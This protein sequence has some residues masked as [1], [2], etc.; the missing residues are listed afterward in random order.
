MDRFF[1]YF[2]KNGFL[3]NL[4]TVFLILIGTASLLTMKRDLVPQ[5]ER[6]RI[7]IAASLIG[8]SPEQIEELL[9][10]PIEE[11]VSSFSGIEDIE[12]TS[13]SSQSDVLINIRDDFQEVD[14]LYEKVSNAVEGIR[15]NLPE[16][17][18]NISI[19]N[20]K[21]TY[22]W[23]LS[24][25]VLGFRPEV[26]RHR[27]WL[28][29]TVD[30]LKK[31]PGI[32]RVE[33]NSPKPGFFFK[34]DRQK[35][36]RYDVTIEDVA[37]KIEDNFRILP[38]GIIDRSEK[39]VS[40]EIDSNLG[41]VEDIG[42]IIVK[43]NASG[44][45][46][47][48]KDIAL[49]EYRN[50]ES[51][52]RSY[53]NGKISQRVVVFKDF[54]TDAIEAKRAVSKLFEEVSRKAPDDLEIKITRD[55]PTYIEKQLKVLSTNGIFGSILVVLSLFLFLGFRS[56]VMTTL[57]LPLAYF[58]TFSVL[59]ALGIGI[60]LISIVGMILI[61]GII[62]DDAII[63]S[64]QYSQFLEKNHPPKE[65]ALM[66]IKKTIAPISGTVLTTIVAF[67]PILASQDGIGS[68]LRAIPWVVIAALAM[69]WIESFFILP[70]HLSHFVHRPSKSRV[71]ETFERIREVYRRILSHVLRLRYV[72]SL[73]MI[74][75]MGFS[76]WFAY[77]NIP[78]K[79]QLRAGVKRIRI[80]SVL[81]ES[82]HFD[83]TEKKLK[84][85]FDL[86]KELDPSR[87]SFINQVLGFTYING[88]RFEGHK[89]ARTFVLFDQED[90][91]IQKNKDFVE[92]FFKKRLP[93]IKNDDF[94]MLQ[95]D[96]RIDG[97]DE[98][99]E[100]VIN[101]KVEG[102]NDVGL[103]DLMSGVKKLYKD[104][105]GFDQVF[106][107]PQLSV[108][109]WDFR[110]NRIALSSY[111]LSLSNVAAQIRGYVTEDS[112]HEFRHQGENVKVFFYFE[113]G[114]NLSFEQLQDIPININ[115]GRWV[116]LK[117]LGTWRRLET[118]RKISHEDL[119]KI[120]NIEI[121]FDEEKTKKEIFK[122]RLEELLPRLAQSF[123]TLSFSLEDADEEAVKNKRSLGKMV[124]VALSLILFVLALVLNSV[125]Q[126]FLIAMAIP[127]GLIGI[128]WAFY[129]HGYAIDV[130]ASIGII[131]MAGVVVNNSLIMVDTIN[132]IIR[133][134]G[135][136]T[137]SAIIE[138]ASSRL[139]P[140]VLT[141][142]TTL[143]GVFPMAYS[144]GGDSSFTSPLALSLGW[145]LL[146]STG[147]TLFLI[148]CM[149]EM[150]S[151]VLGLAR[152][153]LPKSRRPS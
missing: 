14:D 96:M 112:V 32:V 93:E 65:A 136:D 42:N 118:M 6:K 35:L 146:C 113:D 138:G 29:D 48:L 145:G 40:V 87:Y 153:L 15:I 11:A 68:R 27:L 57:G 56:A 103:T 97:H 37:R 62:V 38:L 13:Q 78:M 67:L 90:P 140:I 104:V 52:R 143:G 44:T 10:F 26:E 3:I 79:L 141:S 119:R 41:S 106:I 51:T 49:I 70:N 20:E 108:E 80:V 17:T 121:S 28:K 54:D 148:P 150:Q 139:R 21:M 116:P 69:S 134:T 133:N 59:S 142:I 132:R 137:K 123:P 74:F 8:A 66:A 85:L 73:M 5:W 102:K 71:T 53:T 88:T 25:N 129:L 16:D 47:R 45:Y 111:D 89:Y 36:A 64:E 107:D 83:E 128:I 55:G 77:Q 39:D 31:V 147:L 81:K 91:D 125:V 99:K 2:I 151:D 9:T 72:L 144:F 122:E 109:K 120:I 33:E 4:T 126:P 95:L 60:D 19:V 63:V 12:S 61:V 115:Q 86:M 50:E 7:R 75:F 98:A 149:L 110:F 92:A 127:F 100:R 105:Y 58:A 101:L 76:L 24:F 130:M 152:K 34:F 84:P 94:E 114:D 18:E 30:S 43:S 117:E 23:F 135:R 82:A 131:G 124:I 1:S 22:F 46:I